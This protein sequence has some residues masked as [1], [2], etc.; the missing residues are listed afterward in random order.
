M[1]FGLSYDTFQAYHQESSQNSGQSKKRRNL[2][3]LDSSSDFRFL[4]SF[5]QDF[6]D[7]SHRP[8]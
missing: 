5:F 3:A 8:N 6:G 2:D 4:Q 1:F 7:R